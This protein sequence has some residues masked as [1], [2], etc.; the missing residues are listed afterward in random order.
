M[1]IRQALAAGGDAGAAAACAAGLELWDLRGA[2]DA[3]CPLGD[4][5]VEARLAE[6]GGL[7]AAIHDAE[8]RG[9]DALAA[10][11]DRAG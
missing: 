9:M 1:T 2:L 11:R 10:A 3:D 5:A 8:V 4:H 6:M 7:L